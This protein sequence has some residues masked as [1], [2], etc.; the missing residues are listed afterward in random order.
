MA[1][2]LEEL[3]ECSTHSVTYQQQNDLTNQSLA[4]HIKDPVMV[5]TEV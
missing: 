3:N 2:G 1:L 5:D 4:Q